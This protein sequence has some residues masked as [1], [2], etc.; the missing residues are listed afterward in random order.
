MHTRLLVN[1]VDDGHLLRRELDQL[2]EIRR[3]SFKERTTTHSNVLLH[4]PEIRALGN[5]DR[6]SLNRPGHRDLCWGRVVCFGDLDKVGVVK[7]ETIV[8]AWT[9]SMSSLLDAD[10]DGLTEWRVCSQQDPS[11]ITQFLDRNV[12]KTWMHLDLVYSR[13]YLAVRKKD[14]EGLDRKVGNADGT[15]FA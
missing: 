2:H 10:D 15:D 8:S 14:L 4:A 12:W 1:V 11:S 13:N 3:G 9:L 6:A 5:C 7:E